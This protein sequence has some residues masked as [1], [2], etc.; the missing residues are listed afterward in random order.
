[1][2]TIPMSSSRFSTSSVRSMTRT[3]PNSVWWLIHMMPMVMKLT[4]YAEYC[5]QPM[6]STR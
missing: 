3:C 5:G 6:A 4:T 2:A 1:M